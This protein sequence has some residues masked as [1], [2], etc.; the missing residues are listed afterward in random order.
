MISNWVVLLSRCV[1]IWSRSGVN[2][3]RSRARQTHSRDIINNQMFTAW[4]SGDHCRFSIRNS[5]RSQVQIQLGSLFFPFS[6]LFIFLFFSMD[7]LVY[8]LYPF[9]IEIELKKKI[10]KI[11]KQRGT[12]RGWLVISRTDYKSTQSGR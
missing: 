3:N 2:R 7:A 8:C 10:I 12:V 6:F 11:N 4:C 5:R 1:R 9:K